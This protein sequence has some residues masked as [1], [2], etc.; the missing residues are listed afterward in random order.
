MI[1]P[2][3]LLLVSAIC[4]SGIAALADPSA[5]NG[6]SDRRLSAMD[7][8]HD[9]RVTVQEADAFLAKA[10]RHQAVDHDR[11]PPAR[12]EGNPTDEAVPNLR[13]ERRPGMK[14][15][16]EPT[17]QENNRQPASPPAPSGANLD[18]NR[19]GIISD[20]EFQVMAKMLP[21]PHDR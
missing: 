17:T 14:P 9:G 7:A 16:Q 12:P 18:S 15:Q 1:N 5:T 4:L 3:K 21:A 20:S 8:N 11:R 19:D 10:P 6:E 13:D 2:I